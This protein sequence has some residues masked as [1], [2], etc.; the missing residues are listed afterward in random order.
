M[1]HS[2][3]C[4]LTE[5]RVEEI[6]VE[7]REGTAIKEIALMFDVSRCLIEQVN[8]GITWVVEGFDYPI[9]K[10][11]KMVK[12]SDKS[13]EYPIEDCYPCNEWEKGNGRVRRVYT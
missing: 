4:K 7:L 1:I 11:N 13:Y 3:K 6:Y 10:R 5:E 9:Y 12:V 8:N 2:H